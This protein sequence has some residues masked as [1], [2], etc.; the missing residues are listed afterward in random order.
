MVDAT[1]ATEIWKPIP[2][3]EGLYE[4]STHGRIKRCCKKPHILKQS[5]YCLRNYTRLK[6]RLCKNARQKSFT[7]HTL[8]LLTFVGPK[9]DGMECCHN[10]GDPANNRLENLRWDTAAANQADKIRHGTMACGERINT[11]KLTTA[12]VIQVRHLRSRGFL[13]RELATMFS[14]SEAAIS[15]TANGK[16]WKQVK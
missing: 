4:A 8:I 9:P 10:D 7:V 11:A 3:Y 1:V 13:L 15:K 5:V 14:V 6:V 12:N 16:C 2:G